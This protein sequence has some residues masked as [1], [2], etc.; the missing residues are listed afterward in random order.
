VATL[1]ALVV[2]SCVSYLIAI[3]GEKYEKLADTVIARRKNFSSVDY[4]SY[5]NISLLNG[6]LYSHLTIINDDDMNHRHHNQTAIFAV[7]SFIF[8]L[9]TTIM[10]IIRA[11]L[12]SS[13]FVPQPMNR[14]RN[15]GKQGIPVPVIVNL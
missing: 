6:P 5:T 4:L 10:A 8:L 14:K 12:C 3:R 9:T 15:S 2:S 13:K 1:T 7:L 11:C